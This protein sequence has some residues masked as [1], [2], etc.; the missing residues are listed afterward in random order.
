RRPGEKLYEDLTIKEEDMAVT[1]HPK[2]FI[3]K[4]ANRP[5]EDMRQALERLTELS[6]NGHERELRTYLNELLPE[7]QLDVPLHTAASVAEEET[8]AAYPTPE[9]R[10]DSLNLFSTAQP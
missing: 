10:D 2:I 6:K 4:I 7:A 1:Q 8:P 5:A 3:H 9:Q